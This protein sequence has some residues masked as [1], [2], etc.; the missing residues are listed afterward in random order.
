MKDKKRTQC[1]TA[2]I[3][4]QFYNAHNQPFF[5]IQEEDKEEEEALPMKEGKLR[6]PKK[7]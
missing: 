5:D 6:R 2:P 4:H 7:S 1:T 3:L